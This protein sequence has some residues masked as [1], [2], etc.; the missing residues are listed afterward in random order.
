M[1]RFPNAIDAPRVESALVTGS[2]AGAASRSAGRLYGRVRE[3]WAMETND[4][5]SALLRPADKVLLVDERFGLS[6]G[7][8][9]YVLDKTTRASAQRWLFDLWG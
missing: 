6:Q 3:R 5:S 2:Q 1:R 4:P 8:L 7:R 9:Y